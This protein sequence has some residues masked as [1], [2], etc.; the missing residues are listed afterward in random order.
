M[1]NRSQILNSL[2]IFVLNAWWYAIG[3][4]QS[5][6]F[7]GLIFWFK[8]NI[9]S[10]LLI[11]VIFLASDFFLLKACQNIRKYSMVFRNFF[12]TNNQSIHIVYNWNCRKY[13]FFYSIDVYFFFYLN[14]KNFFFELIQYSMY[15]HVTTSCFDRWHLQ[16]PNVIYAHRKS[17][18]TLIPKPKSLELH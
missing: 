11:I 7:F 3:S 9:A 5:S 18:N 14:R 4:F 15:F 16:V 6:V 10:L 8:K 17:K 13:I 2:D 1:G 12:I